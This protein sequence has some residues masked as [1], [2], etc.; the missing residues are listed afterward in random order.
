LV[1]VCRD[2]IRGKLQRI[3]LPFGRR[4]PSRV[5]GS[6][7]LDF[8]AAVASIIGLSLWS[9]PYGHVEGLQLIPV[10]MG[11]NGSKLQRIPMPLGR[12]R[13]ESWERRC[14]ISAPRL[15]LSLSPLLA[16]HH[17]VMQK[18]Y[19]RPQLDGQQCWQTTKDTAAIRKTTSRILGGAQ[20]DFGAA[21]AYILSP[22][23]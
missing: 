15:P 16:H 7:L 12:R 8:G 3:P 21:V 5:L 18:V 14:S 20:L 10:G 1:S 23:C 22:S 6:A 17:I 11:L 9:P 4:R 19:N 2:S 13:H